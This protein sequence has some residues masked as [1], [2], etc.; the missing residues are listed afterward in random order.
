M[1]GEGFADGSG[2]KGPRERDHAGPFYTDI[3]SGWD[4]DAFG[5]RRKAF[6]LRRGGEPEGMLGARSTSRATRVE[7]STTGATLVIDWQ[8]R[9]E[10]ASGRGRCRRTSSTAPATT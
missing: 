4:H 2:R 5:E 8:R 6:P 10:P 9:V 7:A 1:L 3:S